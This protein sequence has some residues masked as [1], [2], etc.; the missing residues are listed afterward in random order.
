MPADVLSGEQK[1]ALETLAGAG[2][3]ASYYLAG[4]IGLALRLAHRRSADLGFF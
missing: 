3:G 2:V 4:G 1:S